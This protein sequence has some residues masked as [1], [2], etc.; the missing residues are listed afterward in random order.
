MKAHEE[1]MIEQT[2]SSSKR[3]GGVGEVVEGT[4]EGSNNETENGEKEET[5]SRL[6]TVAIDPP[7]TPSSKFNP[8]GKLFQSLSG[9]MD[10]SDSNENSNTLP[11]TAA[12][13]AARDHAS[14]TPTTD[15]SPK[16]SPTQVSISC[17]ESP[18]LSTILEASKSIVSEYSYDSPVLQLTPTLSSCD[19]MKSVLSASDLNSNDGFGMDQNVIGESKPMNPQRGEKS[20]TSSWIRQVNAT[21]ST[22]KTVISVKLPRKSMSRHP[23]GLP[24]NRNFSGNSGNTTG[25]TPRCSLKDRDEKKTKQY[26]HYTIS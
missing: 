15:R 22:Q 21:N 6:D 1:I 10:K 4:G 11:I 3:N 7:T 16:L 24:T 26:R 25:A 12:N 18:S 14:S 2:A 17:E 5:Q 23:T 13:T 8:F 19:S 9:S 20:S